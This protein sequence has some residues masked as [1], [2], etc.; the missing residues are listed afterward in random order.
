MRHRDQ[1]VKASDVFRETNFVF[2][3]KR[4]FE[5]AFPE[6]EDIVIEVEEPSTASAIG[7]VATRS[8]STG[9]PIC[10]ASTSIATILFVIT[11]GSGSAR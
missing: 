11:E 10:R 9:S 3:K 8:T 6:I 5:E 2:S 7:D 1:R 4:P